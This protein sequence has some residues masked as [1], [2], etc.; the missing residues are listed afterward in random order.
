MSLQKRR[1][2]W[3]ERAARRTGRLKRQIQRGI[4]M[5]ADRN[6]F[7]AAGR[8]TDARNRTF[9]AKRTCL[10]LDALQRRTGLAKHSRT[11]FRRVVA[12]DKQPHPRPHGRP[13][14]R[15]RLRT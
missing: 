3:I 2:K 7:A 10:T 9:E 5:R 13:F 8:R 1:H 14:E 11:N 6:P 15:G 4:E 12:T